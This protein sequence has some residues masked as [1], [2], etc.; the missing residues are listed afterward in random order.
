M[1]RYRYSG[2]VATV[3]L[4]GADGQTITY[5]LRPGVEV[6]LPECSFTAGLRRRGRLEE[7]EAPK[8]ERKKPAPRKLAPP[9]PPA[10]EKAQAES[11]NQA[12]LALEVKS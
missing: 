9:S 5:R 10:P 6:E 3:S 7:T 12:P 2:P 11:P 1:N 4:R 8:S